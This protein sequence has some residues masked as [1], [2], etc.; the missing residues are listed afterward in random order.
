MRLYR[1]RFTFERRNFSRDTRRHFGK[2]NRVISIDYLELARIADRYATL[3]NNRFG[4]QSIGSSW[5]L[6]IASLRQL[7]FGWKI[8][9][10]RSEN[11]SL[12]ILGVNN[13]FFAKL[14]SVRYFIHGICIIGMGLRRQWWYYKKNAFNWASAKIVTRFPC[15]KQRHSFL[16]STCAFFLL[17]RCRNSWRSFEISLLWR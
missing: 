5:T 9:H 12:I 2:T 15:R 8:W 3:S 17:I 13:R 16:E 14:R 11:D 6:I 1:I 7:N 10:I 4:M